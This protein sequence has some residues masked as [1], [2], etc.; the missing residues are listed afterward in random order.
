MRSQIFLSSWLLPFDLGLRLDGTEREYGLQ[1]FFWLTV[2]RVVPIL[3]L[4]TRTRD[5]P[6]L[7]L[8]GHPGSGILH[9]GAH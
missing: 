7:R 3:A 2:A 6:G 5:Y 1:T 9:P 8:G 4:P